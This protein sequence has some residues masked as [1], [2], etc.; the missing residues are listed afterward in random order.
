[1]M[2]DRITVKGT[3]LDIGASKLIY[4]CTQ[5]DGT[6]CQLRITARSGRLFLRYQG[7]AN[8]RYA[9]LI[10]G[11]FA[12]GEQIVPVDYDG[13]LQWL[14]RKLPDWMAKP[15]IDRWTSPTKTISVRIPESILAIIHDVAQT[16][17][18]TPGAVIADAVLDLY[19][20]PP[21]E[22]DSA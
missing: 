1:M 15:T 22:D 21:N 19:V 17:N 9:Q 20:K 10:D 14:S 3:T 7:G 2:S 13:A 16:Y 5:D 18:K 12:P 4:G 6:S 8:S 11:Q